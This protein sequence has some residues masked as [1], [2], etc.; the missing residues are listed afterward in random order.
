M[1]AGL[2]PVEQILSRPVLVRL[3][4]KTPDP[5]PAT[6]SGG[7]GGGLPKNTTLMLDG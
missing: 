5:D 6:L 2:D 7:G 4:E 1:T 3:L